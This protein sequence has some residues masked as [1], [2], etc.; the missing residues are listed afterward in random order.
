MRVIYKITNNI[1]GKIYIGKDSRNKKSYMGSGKSIKNAINK[2]GIENFTKEIIDSAN[3]LDE[4]N[5]KEKKWISYYNSYIPSVGYNRSLGGEGN[6]DLSLMPEE[7]V[8]KMRENH[9]LSC[10]SDEFRQRKREDTLK[11]FSDS[12]N[13]IRQSQAIKKFWENSDDE[14]KKNVKER[15]ERMRKKRWDSPGEKEKASENFKINNPAYDPEFR[16]RMSLER[17]GGNNPAS[18]RCLI[19]GVEY[20]SITDAIKD[21]GLTRNQIQYRLRSKN[22]DNYKYK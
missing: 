20:P 16:K 10:R 17:M 18:K 3:S 14:F 8:K 15:L 5:E 1:N 11:H 6:W 12:A 21:L 4:L 9:L 2:Y 22:F 13:R 7:D 19:D